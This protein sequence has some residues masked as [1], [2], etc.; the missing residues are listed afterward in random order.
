MSCSKPKK[1][2]REILENMAN[3]KIDVQRK[4]LS[5]WT[6]LTLR[7]KA[8]LDGLNSADLPFIVISGFLRIPDRW[9]DIP[10]NFAFAHFVFIL[11]LKL[12]WDAEIW[13]SLKKF[14][15]IFNKQH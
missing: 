14:R 12:I 3:L 10:S 6:C 15:A 9:L 1:R 13:K 7:A 5:S 11:N 8:V 2:A 4:E